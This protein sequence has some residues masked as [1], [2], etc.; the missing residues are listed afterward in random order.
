V[1]RHLG[2]KGRRTGPVT[3]SVVADRQAE[4]AGETRGSRGGEVTQPTIHEAVGPLPV[5]EK[6]W[7]SDAARLGVPDSLCLTTVSY[8]AR[9]CGRGRRPRAKCTAA[10]GC[11]HERCVMPA[12]DHLEPWR[13]T[14][15]KRSLPGGGLDR[16]R[17]PGT[18]RRTV[19]PQARAMW[20][21]C[22]AVLWRPSQRD[23]ACNA[24]RPRNSASLLC[25]CGAPKSVRRG[26]QSRRARSLASLRCRIGH[27]SLRDGAWQPRQVRTSETRSPAIGRSLPPRG[28]QSGGDGENAQSPGPPDPSFTDALPELES[29]RD[30]CARPHLTRTVLCGRF[31]GA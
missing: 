23:G 2:P 25:G 18:A 9:T 12:K 24:A 20:R 26:V 28:V 31:R 8:A 3:E 14:Y 22:C 7:A 1:N 17:R 16:A 6:R 4:A 15:R 19:T 27:E 13:T 11:R 29:T 30:R 5:A 10:R 21:P